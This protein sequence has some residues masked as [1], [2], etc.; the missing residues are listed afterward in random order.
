MVYDDDARMRL[1]HPLPRDAPCYLTAEEKQRNWEDLQRRT[2][3]AQ[4]PDADASKGQPSGRWVWVEEK[5]P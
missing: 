3:D 2:K 1:M 4:R 5:K